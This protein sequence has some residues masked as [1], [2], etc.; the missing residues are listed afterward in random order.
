MIRLAVAS[1]SAA[2]MTPGSQP[3]D[4]S[5]VRELERLVDFRYL[6]P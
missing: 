2:V 4:L 6:K 1:A 5:V 3:A